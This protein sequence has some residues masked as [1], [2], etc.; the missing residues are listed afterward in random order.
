MQILLLAPHPFYTERGT[1]IAVKHLCLALS[2]LGHHVD[3]LTYHLGEDLEIPNVSIFRLNGSL[4]I[5]DVP[6]GPS[7]KKL[8][9]D[10]FFYREMKLMLKAKNYDLIH[11]V[12]ES[13][14]FAMRSGKPFVYDMDSH[15]SNQILE[16]SLFYWPIAQLFSK[17]ETAAFQRSIG[18]LAV[19]NSLA[20]KAAPHQSNTHILSDVAME[21]DSG[22]SLPYALE[23]AKGT[24][25]MYV[26][27]LEKYQGI[28]LL[29]EAFALL[30][31][32]ISEATLIIVGGNDKD[33]KYYVNKSKKLA[34]TEKAI[35]TG[36]VPSSKLGS[37]L[38]FSDVLVSPRLKGENT[39]MKVYS[40]LLSGRPVLATKLPTHTQVLSDKEAFLSKPNPEDFCH[41]MAKLSAMPELRRNLGARGKR[42]AKANYSYSAFRARLK[43]FYDS[44]PI[45]RTLQNSI[46]F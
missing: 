27:N 29:L 24:R 46:E 43:S 35:F 39:P 15:M 31:A 7:W 28:D 5:K 18:V 41:A 30:Q 10:I 12:E 2:E 42:L 8:V 21:E 6:I 26:G 1:P 34:I 25:F 37:L 17:L 40:Y 22:E 3:V 9:M 4:F 16:K 19:C 13:A 11:A 32:I 33:I 45:T 23:S 20:D 14:L 36:R 38:T 44:I